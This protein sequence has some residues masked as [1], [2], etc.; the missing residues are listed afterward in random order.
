[1]EIKKLKKT[2]KEL[3]LEIL[4]EDETM[5]NPI[6]Q[7]LLQNEDVEYAEYFTDHPESPKRRFYL[8]VKKGKPEE[9]LK[10]TVKKLETETKTFIKMVEEQTK[11]K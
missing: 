4:H 2:A 8:R 9:I 11:A 5:L 10:Q 3:E 7:L 1:M 6:L